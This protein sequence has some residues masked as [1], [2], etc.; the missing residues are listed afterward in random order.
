M[1]SKPVVQEVEAEEESEDERMPGDDCPGC[2][3]LLVWSDWA[4][5]PYVDGWLCKNVGTCGNDSHGKGSWR[6]NCKECYTDICEPCQDDRLLEEADIDDDEPDEPPP[7]IDPQ[8]E[9]TE[10]VQV[11]TAEDIQVETA[12]DVEVETAE[13][14]PESWPELGSE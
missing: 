2:G 6:W 1:G 4:D 3:E 10:D 8:V 13:D 11:E 12:E 9:T 7:N 14:V 5:G